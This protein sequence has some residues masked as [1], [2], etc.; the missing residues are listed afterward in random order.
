E[1]IDMKKGIFI[2]ILIGMFGFAIY[3]FVLPSDEAAEPE[4]EQ[5][6][7]DVEATAD[8]SIGLEQGNIAP[9]F[10]LHLLDVGTSKLADYRGQRGMLNFWATWCGPCRSE[11][12]YMQK[13]HEN[14]D[15]VILAVNLADTESSEKNAPNFVEEYEL[16]F[17]ILLDEKTEV[18]DLYQIQPIPTSFMIDSNGII[19]NKALGALN[20]ELMVQELEKMD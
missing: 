13:L 19:Q 17:P 2:A 18:A 16:T 12:P 1:I 14:K 20:Y 9:D 10:D 6:E 15:I 5:T 4:N 3:S 8:A 7:E 11:M